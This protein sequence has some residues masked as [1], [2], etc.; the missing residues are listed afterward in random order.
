MAR[1]RAAQAGV[2]PRLLCSGGVTAA[3]DVSLY[4]VEKL[5]GHEIA[6]QTAKSMFTST[7]GLLK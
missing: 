2:V 7:L 4:L 6:M 1:E 5:C 3:A